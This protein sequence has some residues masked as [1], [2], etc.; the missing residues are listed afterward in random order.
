V[1]GDADFENLLDYLRS[2]RGFD[3]SGY[4]R[5]T[6]VRRVQKRVDDLQLSGFGEYRDHLEVHADEFDV[7]FNTIL[8]NVTSFFRDPKAWEYLDH[9]V[10]PRILDAAAPGAPIRIWSAGCASGEEAY[11][12]AMVFAEQLGDAAFRARVKIYATDLDEEALA[13]A[14]TGTYD[15]KALA[16][17]PEPFRDRYFEGPNNER[18][19]RADL[20]R[21]VIF[22]RHDLTRDAPISRLDLVTCRNTLMYFNAETQ[23]GIVRRL[24]Y[25]LNPGAYLFLGRAEMLL[26]YG[27]LFKSVNTPFRIFTKIPQQ[28][29]AQVA[30]TSTA[31]SLRT[32]DR[33]REGLLLHELAQN[34]MR[35]PQLIVDAK[36]L[37]AAINDA[38]SRAFSLLPSDVGRPFQDLEI[39][40]R[41]IDLRTPIDRTSTERRAID[42]HAVERRP[43]GASPEFFEIQVVPLGSPD[44][45]FLG[46]AITFTDVTRL[47]ELQI[48]LKRTTEELETAYEELQS[49]N[50]E[51]ETTNEE[52]QS[53]VEELETTN[54]ELQS[55]NEELETTNEE[56]RSTNE[57]LDTLNE[58]LQRRTDEVSDAN[59]YLNSI[60]DGVSVAVV[61][62]D[63]NRIVRTWNLV[64]EEMW[65]LRAGEVVGRS[66]YDIDS[67]L[68]VE[69]LR[70]TI[71]E[72]LASPEPPDDLV[73][74]AVNRRGRPVRCRIKLTRLHAATRPGMV[75][76][77][78]DS[79]HPR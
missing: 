25:A 24:H 59:V 61:V 64:A 20:R 28:P 48:E 33:E 32:D 51:L 66:L 76:L 6:L 19:F 15:I 72:G 21:A 11:T 23:G 14:R 4:K 1:T 60:V 38:A 7:L 2:T 65:G 9:D 22:G 10:V 17:V 77:I 36:G 62:V 16:D 46:A 70:Q 37:V 27:D 42:L 53:T 69:Q 75:M 56:L 26:S 74:D 78:D 13:H 12:L 39:S 18:S 47:K 40:Y 45:P 31:D 5:P 41:P 34:A 8:I 73:L 30:A 44:G 55:T 35:V 68:P 50:E 79:P 58:M 57:E 49:A 43:A 63:D 67:G 29:V 54:E 52:L 3:F 71:D